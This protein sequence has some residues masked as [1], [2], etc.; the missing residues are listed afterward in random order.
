MIFMKKKIFT[1][2][3]GM[4]LG[5]AVTSL[6]MA[7]S[8][9]AE[10]LNGKGEVEFELTDSPADDANIK[11]VMVTIAE[12]QVDGKSIS[13]FSK[14]TID[15]KAYQEGATKLLASVQVDAKTYRNVVLVL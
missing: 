6:F 5:L 12:I 10:T 14:Q 1:W 4:M 13:G 11:G 9:D 3:K 7:C 8:D 15:V 2:V